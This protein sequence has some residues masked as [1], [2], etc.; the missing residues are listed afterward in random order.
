MNAAIHPRMARPGGPPAPSPRAPRQRILLALALSLTLVLVHG[1]LD[2]GTARAGEASLGAYSLSASLGPG[3]A[4]A[5]GRSLMV[6]FTTYDGSATLPL[7]EIYEDAVLVSGEFSPDAPPAGTYRSDY[8]LGVD[9]ELN[10]TGTLSVS[11]PVTDADANGVPDFLQVSRGASLSFTGTVVPE[12]PYL[13]KAQPMT[14][15]ISRPAG[16]ALGTYEARVQ[17]PAFGTIVYRGETRVLNFGGTLAYDRHGNSASLRFELRADDGTVIPLT[18]QCQFT[19]PSE[20]T[21][22]LPP[23]TLQITPSESLQMRGC[24]LVRAG[25]RYLGGFE[26]ED[27]NPLT[28]WRDHFRWAL[29]IEDPNDE[30]HD[31]IPDLTDGSASVPPPVITLPPQSRTVV[32]GDSVVFSVSASGGEPLSYQWRKDGNLLP[33]ATGSYFA[34]APVRVSDAGDYTVVVSNRA[35]SATSAAATLVVLEP[36]VITGQPRSK[37]VNVGDATLFGVAA[38]GSPPLEFQWYHQGQPV[39]GATGATLHLAAVA[40][41]DAGDYQAIVTNP[42]GSASSAV[43]T[44]TVVAV[45][46]TITGQPR[47]KTVNVGDTTLFGVT[48]TGTPPLAFQWYHNGQPVAGATAATLYLVAVGWSDAGEYQAVVTNPAGSASS[49]V[50]TLAVLG[51]PVITGQ[52]RSK[53]ITEG[54]P[55]LFGV[56]ATGA[57][58]LTFQWTHN[59]VAIPGATAATHVI[60]AVTPADAGE[61]QAVVSNPLGQAAS[62]VALLTVRTLPKAPE[63]VL[64]GPWPDGTVRLLLRG[65]AGSPYRL[66]A[67]SDLTSW[68]EESSGVLQGMETPVEKIFPV[69]PAAPARWWKLAGP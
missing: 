44:L 42:A 16:S 26:F 25:R 69:D 32:V 19:V 30:D 14:G 43:A 15:W 48:A 18:A 8:L 41:T 37:T 47:S 20:D 56:T 31:G 60:A 40:L 6:L 27:G 10:A 4:Q 61:Y 52:P 22:V 45:P 46:P 3:S 11:F 55:A 64:S 28:S 5:G 66:L 50:A 51:P 53:T 39:P 57:G 21:L 12:L 13:Q 1:V 62:A 36:P 7:V 38:T 2:P 33:D 58:P 29:E 67:G 49:A 54:Q 35:G 9:E 23:M 17:D 34:I 59:G 68:V 65:E 24:T 63:L